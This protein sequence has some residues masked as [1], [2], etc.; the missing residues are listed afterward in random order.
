MTELQRC[1][2]S[3]TSGGSP[4]RIPSSSM[5]SNAARSSSSRSRSTRS[6]WTRLRQ[7][8]ARREVKDSSTRVRPRARADRKRDAVPLRRFLAELTPSRLGQPVIFRAT[9]VLGRLPR[10][11]EPAGFLQTMQ[12]REQGTRPDHE[13][14]A[15]DLLDA[16]RDAERHAVRRR[17]APSESAGRACPAAARPAV[18]HSAT[19]ID[20]RYESQCKAASYRMS[21]GE[22]ASREGI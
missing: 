18:G 2:A 6:R 16:P 9:V 5:S 12:A 14:A 7:R 11:G 8:L 20:I 22:A 17:R 15:G 21:I 13:G 3:R 10:R 19:P 4:A 1:G